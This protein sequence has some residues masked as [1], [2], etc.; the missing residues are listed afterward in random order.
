MTVVSNTI[1]LSTE[2]QAQMVDLTPDVANALKEA[3]LQNGIV[4]VS[5]IGSTGAITTI[6]YEPGLMKDIPEIFAKLIPEGHYHHDATWGDGNGHSHL[7][8]SLVGPS[9][10]IPFQNT[11]LVLG[12]WQQ[13]VLIDFDNRPRQ[14]EVFIQFVG[15]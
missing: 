12:T 9:I 15:E 2:G 4:T 6:E 14:R 5:M 3:N 11:K 13:I 1:R 10:T 8:S 7:R